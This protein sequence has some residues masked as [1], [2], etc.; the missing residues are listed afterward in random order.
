MS[1]EASAAAVPRPE[2]LALGAFYKGE[3]EPWLQQH[4]GRRL[5]ARRLRWLIIGGGWAALLAWLY[6]L[7]AVAGDA[8]DFWFWLIFF[9]AIGIAFAGNIPLMSLQADVKK[10]VMNALAGFFKFTYEAKPSFDGVDLFRDLDLLPYHTS[11]SFEDGLAGEIKGVPFRMVEAKLTERRGTGKNAKTVTVFRGLLL[12]LPCQ[13]TGPLAVWRREDAP[14][15]LNEEWREC[16]VDD[17]FF[18]Q[19]YIVH[20]ANPELAHQQL[21]PEARRIFTALD[22]RDDIDNV[23]FGMTANNLLVVVERGAD[24][25]E[26]G[27]M[28]RPLAD[29]DRIQS[30]VDLFAVPFDAVDAFKLQPA[31]MPATA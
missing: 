12:R 20:A 30:M 18:D 28:N 1:T 22:T 13:V 3:L 24:S 15:T 16:K 8:D 29:P 27:K 5:R 19:T 31:A 14:H 6:Y 4:E 26:A 25:F 23:R 9:L 2:F 10:F 7:L 21:D 17:P 11:A